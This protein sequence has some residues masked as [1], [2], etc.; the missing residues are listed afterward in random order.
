MF[1][2]VFSFLKKRRHQ[3][4][5]ISDAAVQ[6]FT[7]S[8][9]V[10]ISRYLFL[11]AIPIQFQLLGIDMSRDAL[12]IFVF[13]LLTFSAGLKM[14]GII[15]KKSDDPTPKENSKTKAGFSG[16]I[17]GILTAFVGAG[18]GFLIVPTLNLALGIDIKKAIVLSLGVIAINS[19]VGVLTDLAKGV[20]YNWQILLPFIAIMF[21]GVFIG[22]YFS[23]KIDRQ[24]LK[25]VFGWFVIALSCF[26]LFKEL[27]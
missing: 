3:P 1:G 4:V 9:G 14:T 17:I 10:F 11:P 18:G 21:A 23:K 26:I 25:T 16:L 8:V 6:A 27:V 12:I 24:N 2:A 19:G 7:S 22:D 13:M 20:S 5:D 15:G